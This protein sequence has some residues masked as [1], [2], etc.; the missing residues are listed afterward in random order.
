MSL[1]IP[2]FAERRY[3]GVADDEL[4]MALPP[5]DLAVAIEGLRGLDRAGLRYPILPYGPQSDPGEGLA[6]SYGGRGRSV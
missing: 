3:G 6:A 1:S 4:L 2:C 5:E